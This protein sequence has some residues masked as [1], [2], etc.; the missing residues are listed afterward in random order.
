MRAVKV[1]FRRIAYFP[2][3]TRE[4]EAFPDDLDLAIIQA[5]E[6]DDRRSLRETAS[7][8]EVA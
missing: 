7:V 5:R 1:P 2:S 8:L 3:G 4:G 6:S